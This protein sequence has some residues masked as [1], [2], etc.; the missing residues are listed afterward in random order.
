MKRR[1]LLARGALTVS[2]IAFSG[3]TERVLV[4]AESQPPLFDDVYDEEEADL[5]VSQK[6]GIAEKA[7]LQAEG[8]ALDDIEELQAYLD[9]QGLLVEAFQKTVEEG[10]RILEL[11]YIDEEF[12]D[13]GSMHSLGIISGGYAALIAGDYPA[14]KLEA[15]IHDSEGDKF[16][17]FEIATE[18]AEQYLEGK[19]TAA[20][21]A[22]TVG[23][24]VKSET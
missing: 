5:P 24:T 11:E 14:D 1:K 19:I 4:E 15:S 21:Y 13:R 7:T 3:C 18:L 16:G 20:T 17:T 22:G 2:I 23:E 6:F 9:E 8:E 12:V 10:E